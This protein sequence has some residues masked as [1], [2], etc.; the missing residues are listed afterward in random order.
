MINKSDLEKLFDK[1][2]EENDFTGRASI[3]QIEMSE[4]YLKVSFSN[5]YKWFLENY[6]S[7]G[8]LGIDILGIA[9]NGISTVKN[10]TERLRKDFNLDDKLYIVE[11][12]DEFFYCGSS[13]EERIY[14]WDREGGIGQVEADN[15]LEFLHD[16]ILGAIEDIE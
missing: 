7:G 1:Y 9:K 12:C 5:D 4:N 10:T 6:G 2:E 16:R 11:D 3:E 14:Y 15:F 13:E 8:V